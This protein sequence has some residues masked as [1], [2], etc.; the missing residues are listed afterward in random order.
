MRILAIIA[1][2]SATGCVQMEWYKHGA[3]YAD[4]E[5][6]LAAARTEA[7]QTQGVI[8]SRAYTYGNRPEDVRYG[9]GVSAGSPLDLSIGF[10]KQSVIQR[11]MNSRGWVRIPADE[12]ARRRQEERLLERPEEPDTSDDPRGRR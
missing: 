12:A 8:D 5:F 10:D 2:V 7:E 4:L 1:L 6:D 11:V 9:G 3:T